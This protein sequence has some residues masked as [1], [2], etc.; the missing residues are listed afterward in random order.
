[1][2]APQE[3]PGSQALSSPGPTGVEFAPKALT[4]KAASSKARAEPELYRD[5]SPE[6]GGASADPS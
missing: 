4:V 5:V 1:M 6:V 2:S 3:Q